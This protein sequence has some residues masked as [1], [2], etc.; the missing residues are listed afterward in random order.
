MHRRMDPHE[1]DFQD[2]RSLILR[3]QI[4]HQFISAFWQ[5]PALVVLA[6]L[7]AVGVNLWR[8][9]GIPLVGDWFADARFSDDSEKSLVISLAD[10]RVDRDESLSLYSQPT[11]ASDIRPPKSDDT[12]DAAKQADIEPAEPGA[13]ISRTQERT[14]N[15]TALETTQGDS[16]QRR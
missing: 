2:K 15:E 13:L 6:M 9:D 7:L 16:P 14:D 10:A 3:R 8:H 4:S 1:D 11:A 12:I 5:M